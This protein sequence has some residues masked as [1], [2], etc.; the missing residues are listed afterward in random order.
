M[1]TPAD[2]NLMN[3]AVQWMRDKISTSEVC[4]QMG[5]KQTQ[6]TYCVY[7]LAIAL[8]AACREGLVK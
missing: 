1:R 5:W 8:R 7:K 4:D 2:R 6:V 3:L